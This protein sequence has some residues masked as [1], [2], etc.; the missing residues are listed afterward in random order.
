MCKNF[1]IKIFLSVVIYLTNNNNNV[2]NS[3][4]LREASKDKPRV[5]INYNA[6]FINK[7]FPIYFRQCL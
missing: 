5:Q 1:K 6:C 3:V 7:V 4:Y 2:S